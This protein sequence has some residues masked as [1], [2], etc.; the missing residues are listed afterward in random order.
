MISAREDRSWVK[1]PKPY[2]GKRLELELW[3]ISFE[4]Y[5]LFN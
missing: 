1:K 5:Y 2:K 4:L 3:L